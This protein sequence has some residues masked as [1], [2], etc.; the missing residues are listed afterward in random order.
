MFQ[1]FIQN[2]VLANLFF[3]LVLVLGL[4]S[5][6]TLPREQDPTI[7]FNWVQ[8][9]TSLPGASAV[10]IEKRI[11]DPLEEVIRSV[12][13]IKFV[14][15]NSREGISSI[16]IRFSDISERIFDKRIADL[17]REIQNKQNELPDEASDPFIFEITTDNAYPTASI[18]AISAAND[19]N[20]RIQ[21]ER[22]KKEL[23][24]IKGID[25]VVTTALDDP[26]L[27]VFFDPQTLQH[28]GI[29][30]SDLADT[31]RSYYQDTPAGSL[32]V[33]SEEWFIRLTG[34]NANADFLA[35]LPILTAQGK[36]PLSEV[37]EVIRSRE[38]PNQL[39]SF[40]NQAAVLYAITKKSKSNTLALVENINT[41]IT[42]RNTFTESTGVQLVLIDDS[43]EI[44]NKSIHVMQTNALV[45]LLFVMIVTWIFLGFHIA[46]LTS[47]GIP[48]I[49]A[50][51]FWV[52]SLLDSSLNI[53][54]L[55]GVV[56]SLGM[57]VDD[58]VV[59][60]EAIHQRLA[61]GA[62][63]VTACIDSL[64]EVAAP[65]TTAVLTTISAFLPLM[66]MPG[67]MGKF[68]MVVPMVVSI[69]LAISLIE[70]F[71][72]LPAHI[73][74]SNT[75]F[76]KPT[77]M[78]LWRK[79]FTHRLQ[80]TYIQMLLKVMR[81]PVRA[82]TI[83]TL[84][85]LLAVGSIVAEMVK[86]DF[87]ASDPIRKF[88]INI[89]MP[90]GTTLEGTLETTLK[91][92]NISRNLLSEK[93]TRALVSYAGQMFTETEPFFG[94][95]YGQIMISLN[96]DTDNNLRHVD[97]VLDEIRGAV[98]DYP[99]PINIS[100]FRLAGGPPVTKPISVKVRGD[101]LQQI[102]TATIALKEILEDIPAVQD[103]TDDSS[104]GRN[105]LNLVFDSYAI[106]NSGL[107]P[108]EIARNLRLL[109]D[110]EVV[111]SMQHLGE[112]LEVRVKAKPRELHNVESLLYTQIALP[113]GD[114]RPLSYFLTD[115]TGKGPG[116]IRHHNYRRAITVEAGL[117]KK[118]MNTVQV[119]DLIKQRWLEISD[120]FTENDLDFTGELDD[121][122]ESFNSMLT[123]FLFGL[124]LIYAILGTQFKS[125]F[126]PLI[127]LSTVP[128][129]FT[130]VTIG[131]LITNN[132]LSL[133]TMYGV[134][135]LAGIAVNAAIVLISAANERLKM[136]MSITHAT[137]Y[138]ARRRIIPILITTFTTIA[139]LSSLAL[140][141]GGESLIWGPV[142]T[143]IVWGVG[144]SSL[145][146]LFA[147]PLLFRL[148]MRKARN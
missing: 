59:V 16:L 46:A 145:L 8:I 89:E 23:E 7:N 139:G 47:I 42:H 31:I 29:K 130:G 78:Y 138:A 109:V 102:K 33:Q 73:I 56:I 3:V 92:E 5:Y 74:A 135:A 20:L 93:E 17:R 127:I 147:I 37:A 121:I 125:Y 71:W 67:I 100:F 11:T 107:T 77:K 72:M 41:F 43:T 120:Q 114:I 115:K 12:S 50:G 91:I 118:Q 90:P 6:L 52:I 129:A 54:V 119:N 27:Q 58:A 99:G 137:I 133:Y 80:I 113:N 126:Q 144:F 117:D 25:R 84:A 106:Q 111:A 85:F 124:L 61:R 32:K 136:G 60:V 49:L 87:F 98:S 21:S 53:M 36:V 131:L 13:D 95:N 45:G 62:D 10:D 68:L 64:K 116:N 22:I 44:T 51:T 66:L 18:V 26:E 79:K 94:N 146:T 38:K 148:F 63:R 142:A 108:A 112:E 9:T 128:M 14:S 103:I 65:V 28:Y 143:A 2:H 30:P 122:E 4:I 101:D 48:F 1:R 88:Y 75:E 81:Y 97:T 123:L 57:L 82:L 55:L 96:P 19:E 83:I 86:I 15:S 134:V 141:L 69:A 34:T 70:A 105:E 104:K 35:T 110:G 76:N 24:N 40:N 39:V 132:P 140:G